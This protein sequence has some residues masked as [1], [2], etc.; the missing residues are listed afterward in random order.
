MAES[1][2]AAEIIVRLPH[3]LRHLAGDQAVIH[4]RGGTVGG[5]IEEL[6]ARYPA[7]R[8]RLKDAA[9]GLRSWVLF[10]LNDEDIRS[11]EGEETPVSD[12][13]TLAIVLVAE[14]G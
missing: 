9:G 8:P 1:A 12:G 7:L 14:G 5:A 10:F 4:V 6:I 3:S 11:R 2:R 13:D